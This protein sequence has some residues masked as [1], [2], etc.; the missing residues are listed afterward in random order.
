MEYIGEDNIVLSN[1]ITEEASVKLLLLLIAA[2]SQKKLIIL[3]SQRIFRLRKMLKYLFL[4]ISGVII[5][6]GTKIKCAIG[7]DI[8]INGIGKE[9]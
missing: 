2:L 6:E 5:G 8:E 3:S 9:V 7:D 4:I 1:F